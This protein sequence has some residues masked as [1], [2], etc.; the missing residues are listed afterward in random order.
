[1]LR[2]LLTGDRIVS[3]NGK[4]VESWNDFSDHG[5][6]RQRRP[7]QIGYRAWQRIIDGAQELTI[8]PKREDEPRCTATRFPTWII[9]V[10]PRGD[11]ET[12]RYG[13]IGAVEHGLARPSR[14][15]KLW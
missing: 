4:P 15:P 6:R 11:E 5:E 14:W 2:D 3:V 8:T 12:E 7:D 1:M 10:L 9:G 13:P